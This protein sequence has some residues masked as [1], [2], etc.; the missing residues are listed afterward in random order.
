MSLL[1][2]FKKAAKEVA[3]DLE[4]DYK[5]IRFEHAETPRIGLDY[6]AELSNGVKNF[7]FLLHTETKNEDPTSG[8]MKAVLSIGF[9]EGVGPYFFRENIDYIKRHSN[10]LSR[11]SS[12]AIFNCRQRHQKV[13]LKSLFHDEIVRIYGVPRYSSTAEEE[14]TLLFHG[15]L[16]TQDSKVLVYKFRHISKGDLYRSFSYAFY[17]NPKTGTRFWVVFPRN[18]GLDSGGA[19]RT[20]QH[21]EKLIKMIRQKLD[22]EIKRYD[23]EYDELESFLLRN[24]DSFFSIYR[25]DALDFPYR[26]SRPSKVLEGSEKQYEKFIEGYEEKEYAQAMRDLRALVQQA[27]ENVAKFKNLDYS[28][29]SEPNINKLASFLIKRKQLEGRLQPWF[30]AFAS[31][32][33]IASHK[34]FPSMK[35]MQNDIIRKRVLLTF[36]LGVQL[37]TELDAIVRPKFKLRVMK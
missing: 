2:A 34:D 14:A 27:Q 35:D 19:Y 24:A 37:I 13:N 36:Y 33:N 29:I 23:V 31:V 25:E 1:K 5:K 4:M 6:T 21:F 12:W 26:F 16:A 30:G 18:C 3:I 20:Y 7:F 9:E 8:K 22:V 11:W 32:A 28:N 15:A 10:F 17:V